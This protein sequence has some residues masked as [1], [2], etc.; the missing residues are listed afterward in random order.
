MMIRPFFLVWAAR[1]LTGP[2]MMMKVTREPWSDH[3]GKE[4]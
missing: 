2:A 1:D 3:T 4:K